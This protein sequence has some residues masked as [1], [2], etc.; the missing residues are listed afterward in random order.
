MGCS[1]ILGVV[2]DYD[3]GWD[4]DF[5]DRRSWGVSTRDSKSNP[6]QMTSSPLCIALATNP[7]P[8][9]E[10]ILTHASGTEVRR[11][12]VWGVRQQK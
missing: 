12:P 4:S 1:W 10:A 5:L 2:R 7:L 8:N 6:V 3:R 9:A 11:S